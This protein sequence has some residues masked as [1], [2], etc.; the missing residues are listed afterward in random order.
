MEGCSGPQLLPGGVLGSC[1][2]GW[3]PREDLA[4]KLLFKVLFIIFKNV[5]ASSCKCSNIFKVSVV[6]SCFSPCFKRNKLSLR[7]RSHKKHSKPKVNSEQTET[8]LTP[9]RFQLP[10]QNIVSHGK[11][12]AKR[13]E[14]RLL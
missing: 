6:P 9:A 11:G 7:K 3:S 5:F 10:L 14:N 2:K 12:S 4:E 1:S 13:W 8:K